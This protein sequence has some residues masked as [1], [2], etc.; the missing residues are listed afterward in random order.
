LQAAKIYHTK[1]DSQLAPRD[2]LTRRTD[3]GMVTKFLSHLDKK[4]NRGKN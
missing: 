2:F 4:L 3:F 1:S